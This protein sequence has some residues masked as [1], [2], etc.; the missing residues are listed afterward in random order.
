MFVK[1]QVQIIMEEN[2]AMLLDIGVPKLPWHVLFASVVG[3]ALSPLF[4]LYNIY[5][6]IRNF[7]NGTLTFGPAK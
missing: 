3:M 1:R 7:M 5:T 6:M 4:V 2:E